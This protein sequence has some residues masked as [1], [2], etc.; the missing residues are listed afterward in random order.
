MDLLDE[1]SLTQLYHSAVAAFP[2]T[3]RRQHSTNTIKV[4]HLD[5]IPF[6]GMKTL[7]VK[8]RVENEGRNYDT[9][10]LFKKVNYDIHEHSERTVHLH[11]SD[12]GQ[13]KFERLDE[14]K[15]EVVVRCNCPDFKWRWSYWNHVEGSLYGRKPKPY[16]GKGGPPANPLQM[17]G[18]CKHIMKTVKALSVAGIFTQPNQEIP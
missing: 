8:G 1:S 17:E 5:W 14:E 7:F 18:C 4:V 2:N 9:I 16:K 3:M 15:T 12:G 6:V 10:L 13:Y 11:A